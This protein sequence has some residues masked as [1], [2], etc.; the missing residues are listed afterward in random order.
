M[1]TSSTNCLPER[2]ETSGVD[3]DRAKPTAQR[4]KPKKS[5][6]L[7]GIAAGNTALCT[8]G[9]SGNDLH[10]RGYDILDFATQGEFEEIALSAGARH[11]AELRRA[12]RLQGT[13]EIACAACPRTVKAALEQLPAVGA[14]DGRDAHRRAPRSA[15]VLPEKDDHNVSRRARHRRPPDGHRFGSM[16]LYWHHFSHNGKR[17]EVETDDD[18]IGGHFLH[19][20]HG[21][22]PSELHAQA[23]AHV[24]DP[25]RRARVQRLAPSPRASSPAPARTCI[26][27]SP[28]RSVR[29]VA[30]SM[31]APTKWRWRSIARYRTA[32]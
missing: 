1:S 13:A 20:L 17:I 27:P 15:R 10:Y 7:S 16:L 11:A 28:A 9:R 14:S 8:V 32:G 30:R 29:C 5:V 3:V 24:A 31:A 12:H 18:S 21:K 25:V 26:R 22:E 6:A 19:L 4:F 2:N 23:H